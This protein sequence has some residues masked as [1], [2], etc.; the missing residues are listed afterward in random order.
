[1]VRQEAGEG[2]ASSPIA[3]AFPARH[4]APGARLDAEQAAHAMMY[5]TDP[6]A[7][8]RLGL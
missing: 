4:V 1:L 8:L 2:G 6:V 3:A 7:I 5:L